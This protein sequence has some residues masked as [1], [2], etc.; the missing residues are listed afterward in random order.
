MFFFFMFAFRL[1]VRIPLQ[2]RAN[3][4]E[5]A[6]F[7]RLLRTPGE[8]IEAHE[9]RHPDPDFGRRRVRRRRAFR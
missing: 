2:E 4:A 7:S 3:T 6:L 1:D 5:I 8:E 9:N